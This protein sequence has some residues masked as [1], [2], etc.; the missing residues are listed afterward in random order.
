[1]T[2]IVLTRTANRPTMFARLRK[3]LLE[4]TGL[5]RVFHIV[6]SDTLTDAYP[7]GDLVLRGKRLPKTQENSAPWEQY[8]T[9]MLEVALELFDGKDAFVSFIDDDDMY[10]S[11]SS[12]LTMA[13]HVAPGV[14]PIWKV[15][16]EGGRVSPF[17][18]GADLRSDKG[19]ICWEASAIH[20][21]DLP[22]ALSIGIDGADGGDGRFWAN[23]AD[24]LEVKW[25]NQTLTKPQF[26]KGHGR[27]RDA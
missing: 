18:F 21:S 12:L 8:H 13:S 27:R 20:V 2:A 6:Y 5:D 26:G 23:L 19:R 10:T 7:R 17:V 11:R 24:H 14:M 1:M 16:R 3:S 9:S 22:L 15:Q 4:Q 25:V